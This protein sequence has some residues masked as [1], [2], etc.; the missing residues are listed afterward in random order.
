MKKLKVTRFVQDPSYC[1]VAASA[2]VANY[3]NSNINY[4][5]AKELTIKK[6]SKKVEGEGLYTTEIADLLNLLGFHKV[7]VITTDLD[8]V[9]YA[10]AKY[11]KRRLIVTMEDAVNHKRDHEY[12]NVTK[13]FVKW[14]KKD[15]YD[16]SI[17]I[18]YD[19]SKYIKQHLNRKKP[20]LLF[21]NWTRYMKFPKYGG[22]EADPINGEEEQHAVAVN[23]YDNKGVWVIDSHNAFYKYKRKKYRR[24][25]YKIQWEHLL[26]CMEQGEIILPEEYVLEG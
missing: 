26:T 9:D 11:G 4:E 5:Y 19:F 17:K 20:L 25:F 3:Y 21:F 12:R 10:W 2:T 8:I 23:G 22:N 15:G 13:R 24:G 1:A 18:D 14:L 16:N 7:T 6:V